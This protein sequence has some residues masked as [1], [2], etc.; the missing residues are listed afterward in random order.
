MKRITI[1]CPDDTPIGDRAILE[2]IEPGAG[3]H[4]LMLHWDAEHK[5]STVQHSRLGVS[6]TTEKKVEIIPRSEGY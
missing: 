5:C 1:V 3:D 4:T 2:L 6:I